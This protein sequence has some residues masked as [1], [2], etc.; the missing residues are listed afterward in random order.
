[1]A[2]DLKQNQTAGREAHPALPE[3]G[4]GQRFLMIIGTAAALRLSQMSTQRGG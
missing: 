4:A 2:Q 3:E 1:M